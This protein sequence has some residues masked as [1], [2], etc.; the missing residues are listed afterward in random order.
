[1]SESDCLDPKA[2]FN[3]PTPWMLAAT[4]QKEDDVVK[5]GIINWASW[6]T[7][8]ATY[9]YSYAGATS[10][11]DAKMYNRIKDSDFRKL[12]FK[13]PAGHALESKVPFIDADRSL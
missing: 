5:T 10:M 4:T 6:M 11:I 8:E 1:M 13:A 7:P 3:T 2:G 12:M 9:G